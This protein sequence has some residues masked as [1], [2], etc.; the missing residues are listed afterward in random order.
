[1]QH[2]PAPQWRVALLEIEDLRV[3]FRSSR[4]EALVLRGVNLC[5]EKH[6]T[7]GLV[8]ESGSG[9]SMTA[10]A[11]MNLLPPNGRRSAT[12][13]SLNGSDLRSQREAKMRDLRGRAIGMVFQDPSTAL[14]PV[15]TIGHQITSVRLRHF[16]GSARDAQGRAVDLLERVGIR[17]AAERLSQYPHQLSG[18]LKQRV[19][20]A[21]ALIAEPALLLAD[22]PTTALDVT[23]Q[24]R[25][26]N[27]LRG[28]QR[29]LGIGILLITHD[30]GVVAAAADRVAVMYAGQIVETGPVAAVLT[31]PAHPY[32]QGLLGCVPDI[33]G[34]ARLATITGQVPSARDMPAGCAFAPRCSMAM[35][36]CTASGVELRPVGGGHASRCL[37]AEALL[38]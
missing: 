1:M 25:V 29:E 3:G 20:I 2:W 31:R 36:A 4:G 37:K 12:R 7:L 18:G 5:V 11:T 19:L 26:L 21:M 16:P 13:L 17:G 38:A 33:A 32:T 28:L 8:G 27:L 14:N 22:E 30:L 6:E 9:K 35:P 23:V 10:L 15:Q 34:G 24:A